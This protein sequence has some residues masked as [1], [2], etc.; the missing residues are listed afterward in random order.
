MVR[1][2]HVEIFRDGELVP[3][4]P[5]T[6]RVSW[7]EPRPIP[8]HCKRFGSRPNMPDNVRNLEG[9]GG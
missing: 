8:V 3:N 9:L 4:D 6:Q 1:I 7:G 5:R 2:D